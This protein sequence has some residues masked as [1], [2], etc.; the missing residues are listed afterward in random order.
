[1]RAYIKDFDQKYDGE[2]IIR[3]ITAVGPIE[4]LQRMN[5][6]TLPKK[7]WSKTH[8]TNFRSLI[9][10]YEIFDPKE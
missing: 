1:M 4:W 10:V 8:L 7:G 5:S 3:A 9:S 6:I 2:A